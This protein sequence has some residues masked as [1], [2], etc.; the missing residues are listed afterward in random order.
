[1]KPEL[2]QERQE[3]WDSAREVFESDIQKL[4]ARLE[5]RLRK[6]LKS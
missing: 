3:F 6:K 5:R 1:M 2:L 4:K